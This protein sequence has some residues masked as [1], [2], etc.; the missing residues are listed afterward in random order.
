MPYGM[1]RWDVSNSLIAAVLPYA[2]LELRG[3][4]RRRTLGIFFA[5]VER[6]LEGEP[7]HMPNLQ[8]QGGLFYTNACGVAL[9]LEVADGYGLT[10][11]EAKVASYCK[12]LEGWK[13]DPGAIAMERAAW[14]GCAACMAAIRLA[15]NG[16]P[17]W[18]DTSRAVSQLGTRYLA[19]W[20]WELGVPSAARSALPVLLVQVAQ[21][22]RPLDGPYVISVAREVHDSATLRALL[23]MVGSDMGQNER[24]QLRR[25]A[26]ERASFEA[27]LG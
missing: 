8:E 20:T 22:N 23:S 24:D 11:W 10:W 3:H 12:A 15:R 26:E 18:G 17:T 6:H 19:D 7:H 27:S 16:A 9:E 1:E 2:A 4:H 5:D 25:F 14:L 21:C 13:G